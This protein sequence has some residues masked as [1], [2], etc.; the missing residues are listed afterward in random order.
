MASLPTECKQKKTNTQLLNLGSR[1]PMG[2]HTDGA[3]PKLRL[4]VL[5]HTHRH[6][7]THTH[8]KRK[9]A[10]RMPARAVLWSSVGVH[11]VRLACDASISVCAPHPVAISL[12]GE[13]L[14]GVGVGVGVGGGRIG[15]GGGGLVA[16][17]DGSCRGMS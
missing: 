16:R 13:V 10:E 6:T 9:E 17:S 2:Q 3:L 1:E 4:F 7:H 14:T 15:G 12:R 8:M 5:T 11:S